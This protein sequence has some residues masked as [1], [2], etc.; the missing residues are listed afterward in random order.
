[1][2]PL[3]DDIAQALWA[4]TALAGLPLGVGVAVG[5]VLAMFQA[6][7]QIQEQT[8]IFVPKLAAVGVTLFLFAHWIGE[9]L[10][11]LL[12]NALVPPGG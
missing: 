7:S 8:L 6:A 3:S 9:L 4:A 1:M 11:A 12:R 10:E 2:Q 5:T